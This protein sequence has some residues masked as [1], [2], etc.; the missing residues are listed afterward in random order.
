MNGFY[1]CNELY[2]V[3]IFKD[4]VFLFFKRKVMGEV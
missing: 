4:K 2:Y 1:S 3:K